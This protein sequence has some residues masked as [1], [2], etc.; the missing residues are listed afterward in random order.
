MSENPGYCHHCHQKFGVKCGNNFLDLDI[1]FHLYIDGER[2]HK[3]YVSA[4][5]YRRIE[6]IYKDSTSVL[7]FK[8]QELE[9]VGTFIALVSNAY[10]SSFATRRPGQWGH[11]ICSYCT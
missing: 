1:S 5:K 9:L 7:P 10:H 11:G 2:V 3:A 4:G 8:F 6:G